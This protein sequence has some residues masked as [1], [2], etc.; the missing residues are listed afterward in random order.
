[1]SATDAAFTTG[2]LPTKSSVY[3]VRPG[4]LSGVNIGQENLKVAFS[5]A[6]KM[7]QYISRTTVSHNW[8]NYIVKSAH[9]QTC[10]LD[11]VQESVEQSFSYYSGS[12]GTKDDPQ[13]C[14]HYILLNV[15]LLTDYKPVGIR[16]I[17]FT[18][19]VF[20]LSYCS[21]EIWSIYLPSKWH[22]PHK[23]WKT[24]FIFRFQIQ[25]LIIESS[26]FWLDLFEL[27]TPLTVVHGP[28]IDELHQQINSW[29]YQVIICYVGTWGKTYE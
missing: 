19:F 26:S 11:L 29:I 23:S 2:A 12:N 20:E 1:M 21:S 27:Q 22:F 5:A 16:Q 15:N 18:L 17:K 13:V 14:L 6:G 3:T 28:I 8:E 10:S 4:K 7:T 24:G 25:Q 9:T